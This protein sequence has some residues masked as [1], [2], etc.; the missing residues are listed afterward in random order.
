[1]LH[2]RIE[3]VSLEFWRPSEDYSNNQS[4]V[5]LSLYAHGYV[6]AVT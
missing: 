1:M 6:Y 2:Q 4:F 5:T 3:I